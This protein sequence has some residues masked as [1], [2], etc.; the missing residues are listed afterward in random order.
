MQQNQ[1][2]QLSNVWR[3]DSLV[4][5]VNSDVSTVPDEPWTSLSSILSVMNPLMRFTGPSAALPLPESTP[6]RG[7]D[8]MTPA[9]TRFDTLNAYG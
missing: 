6:A 8:G 3:R 5:L 7:P 4:S 2:I 9:L 1:R